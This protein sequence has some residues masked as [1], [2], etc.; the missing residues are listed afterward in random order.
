LV[1]ASEKGSIYDESWRVRKDKTTFWGSVTINA[2][3]DEDGMV[4]GFAKITRDLTE[5]M[6]AENTIQQHLHDLELKNKEL[7]QFAYIASHDL[8][9]P[10]L[11][12]TNFY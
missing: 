3:Y 8:Q 2:L 12:I 9:E 7:E 6:L 4:V 10:L 1:E 5:K 11:T